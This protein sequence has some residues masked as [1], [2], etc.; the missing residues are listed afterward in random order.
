MQANKQRIRFNKRGAWALRYRLM[1]L[2]HL[3]L[4][5][6]LVMSMYL[7][8]SAEV[9]LRYQMNQVTPDLEG[10]SY[11]LHGS[12]LQTGSG[13]GD[14]QPSFDQ[15]YS[16]APVCLLKPA[17]SVLPLYN[18][19]HALAE[20][21]Y[22]YFDA[23]VGSDVSS[24]DLDSLTFDIA[25]GG[26]N[27]N[28]GFGVY[29]TS[30]TQLNIAVKSSTF[31]TAVR[32]NWSSQTI[33]L[34]NV[35]SLQQLEAGDAVRV[36]IAFWTDASSQSIEV[37]NIEL[38]G[39][40]QYETHTDPIEPLTITDFQASPAQLTWSTTTN[41]SYAVDFST[42]LTTT[43]WNLLASNIAA[44]TNDRSSI[45]V[46]EASSYP[47]SE[48]ILLQYQMG[49]A[50]PHVEDP[51]NTA[52]GGDLIA[53]I[54]L[55]E[56]RFDFGSY[57]T[58]PA[59]LLNFNQTGSNLSAAIANGNTFSFTLTTGSDVANLNL[60]ELTFDAARGGNAT[61]R[62]YGVL[63]N[64]PTTTNELVQGATDVATVRPVWSPQTIDL[65]TI[66]SLQGLQA[67]E[68]VTF[69]IPAYSPATGNSLE[70][71]NITVRGVMPPELPDL[72]HLSTLFFKVRELAN[73]PILVESA[74][75]PSSSWNT[76]S[77][78][79][80]L[81]LPSSIE[82][83]TDSLNAYGGW[84]TSQT[85]ATGFFYPLKIEGR[86]WLVDPS[87]HLCLHKGVTAV[88]AVRS[89]GAEDAFDDIFGSTNDWALAVSTLFRDNGFNGTGS[90]SDTAPLS[91]IP[92]PLVYTIKARF[93]AAYSST[94][95]DYGYPRVFD[96]NFET[97]CQSH[98]QEFA[99]SENDPYLLG[100]FSDNE[101]DFPF[102][103]LETWLELSSGYSYQEAWRWLRERYGNNVE[104]NE[105]TTQ[106]RYDFLGHVWAQYYRIVNETIK[107]QDPN[108][109][110]LGSRFFQPD[111]NREEIFEAIGPHVD[112]ISVNHYNQWTP[113]ISRIQMWEAESG[114]PVIISEF[115]TKG[116]DSNMPNT[117]G[118]G[119]V[120][121]TQHD[122]GLFY[123]NFVLALLESKACVGWHWF[124]YADND[125]DDQT[126]DPSNLDSNKGLI[127]NRYIP[128]SDLLEQI[129]Q[130]NERA[131]RI[132][133]YFDTEMQ[134]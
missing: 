100:Y 118:A 32:P 104:A 131:Y 134:P 116:E 95:S 44:G 128:Y 126:A 115:Y 86:W 10:S 120:V 113:D 8:A 108:H 30:P 59:M 12:D 18:A 84:A 129:R 1:R 125:P 107:A 24:L 133:E 36:I 17:S 87:G 34:S 123:Q 50:T 57:S 121:R 54:G 66:N 43:G 67:G 35:S 60:T 23:I 103:L 47:I 132:T 45:L 101:L 14:F 73:D 81:Q 51:L 94:V 117:T 90:W 93:L 74:K 98:F 76:Y 22:L 85:N 68:S 37:D 4:T 112:I 13:V 39:T 33:D 78:R 69:I 21:C 55:N 6:L 48:N 75:T 130:L 5:P 27:A 7:Q 96:P 106:D 42:N 72:D 111:M 58:A 49:Q 52:A 122:R 16:S 119:W 65:S 99:G 80:L 77:T 2:P 102:D 38:L 3:C 56:F 97:Y 19:G 46:S 29:V 114:R 110:F 53:G 28:R 62:G 11:G 91:A 15:F 41:R 124:K 25:R 83:S 105:I 82:A 26:S 127:S 79:T 20:R 61:P 64:T 63:V 92:N 88:R 31:I 9:L 89:D 70:F 71:D 40:P 109:L